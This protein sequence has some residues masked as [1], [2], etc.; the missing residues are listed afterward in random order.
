M[1]DDT[2]RNDATGELRPIP[3]LIGGI[4]VRMT[5][6]HLPEGVPLTPFIPET[7]TYI[8]RKQADGSYVARKAE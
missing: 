6:L 3:T 8:M 1:S 7:K 2:Y 4:P 5:D